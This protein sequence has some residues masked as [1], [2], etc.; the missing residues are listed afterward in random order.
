MTTHL[1]IFVL[2]LRKTNVIVHQPPEIS[3]ADV[4]YIEKNVDSTV[5]LQCY[6]RGYPKPEINWLKDGAPVA[7]SQRVRFL[8]RLQSLIIGRILNFNQ[9]RSQSKP[10]LMYRTLQ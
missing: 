8:P 5:L 9:H 10:T 4:E 3:G 2:L 6:A 7:F 1:T